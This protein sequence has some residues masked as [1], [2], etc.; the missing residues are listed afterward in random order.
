MG[1][2]NNDDIDGLWLWSDD[3]TLVLR[4]VQMQGEVIVMLKKSME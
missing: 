4:A 1:T 2:S 3:M